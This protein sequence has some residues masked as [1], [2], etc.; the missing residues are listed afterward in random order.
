MVKLSLS[1]PPF[2]DLRNLCLNTLT[3]L[4][5]ILLAEDDEFDFDLLLN[6]MSGIDVS[7]S[8]DRV[9]DGEKLL[10]KLKDEAAL[11]SIVNEEENVSNELENDGT[12]EQQPPATISTS[13]TEMVNDGS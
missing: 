4:K 3:Q 7:F 10:S 1:I 6:A 8:L 2:K 12:I 5:R 9:T 13:T 11:S